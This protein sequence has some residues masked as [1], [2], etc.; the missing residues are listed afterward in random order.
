MAGCNGGRRW[1]LCGWVSGKKHILTCVGILLALTFGRS[2]LQITSLC[3]SLATCTGR[4]TRSR[5]MKQVSIVR[6][7]QAPCWDRSFSAYSQTSSADAKSMGGSWSQLSWPL[8][9]SQCHP[10][11]PSRLLAHQERVHRR[12]RSQ[13]GSSSG[14]S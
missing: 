3:R 2:F 14:D 4:Q 9:L 1:T 13:V 11:V 5:I 6:H 7:W 10:M 8:L 12:C